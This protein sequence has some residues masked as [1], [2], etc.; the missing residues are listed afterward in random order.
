M[1]E[2]FSRRGASSNRLADSAKAIQDSSKRAWWGADTRTRSISEVGAPST[3]PDAT[4]DAAQVHNPRPM[5][6]VSPRSA[7][8]DLTLEAFSLEDLSIE[9]VG[10]TQ[11]E[12]I[13]IGQNDLWWWLAGW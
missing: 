10:R 11:S 6:A 12:L 5:G 13:D 7:A 1:W 9:Q 2:K 8:G 4:A 3:A